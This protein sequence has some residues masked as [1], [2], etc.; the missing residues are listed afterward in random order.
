[1]V[2]FKLMEGEV[3][4]LIECL[5]RCLMENI[6]DLNL[7]VAYMPMY[8]DEELESVKPTIRYIIKET[9]D[10]IVLAEHIDGDVKVD[11]KVVDDLN[12]AEEKYL[13]AITNR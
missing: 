1:M 8:D 3:K 10:L 9:R 7:Y 2:E 13:A 5:N 6:D 12:D 11:Q 4:T